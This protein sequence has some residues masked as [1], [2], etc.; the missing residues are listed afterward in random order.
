LELAERL[1]SEQNFVA[2][3]VAGAIATLLSAVAYGIVVRSLPISYGFA[4]AGVGTFIGFFVGFLGRGIETKFSVVAVGYTIAGCLL[5]NLLVKIVSVARATA[6]NP[7][8]VF[9]SSS[10]PE[11][12]QW[13][14]AGL[15]LIHIVYWFVAVF[16]AG[17]L[18]RRSLSREQRL[19][20]GLYFAHPRQ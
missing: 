13:S 8:D 6:S 9:R 14:V 17:F 12:A 4:A 19:A 2:A 16:A 15:T 3:I 7:I 1:L 20:I 10:L 11:L 5:G 18:A